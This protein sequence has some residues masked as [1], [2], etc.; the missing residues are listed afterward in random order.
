MKLKGICR[1]SQKSVPVFLFQFRGY[2]LAQRKRALENLI[3]K[4]SE[5][6]EQARII[7]AQVAAPHADD[8][9]RQSRF[10]RETLDAAR[11]ARL[12]S[13][14]VPAEL[15]GSGASM[16][17]LAAMCSALAQGCAASGMVLAMHHIQVASIARH[18]LSAPA[19]CDYL[20][21]LAMQQRLIASVTSEMGTGGDM[22]SSICAVQRDGGR[23]SVEKNATTVS[24]GEHADDLLLTCRRDA[25]SPASD[26][27][28][29]LL[30]KGNFALERTGNW[31]TLGMRGTCSP[32]FKVTASGAETDIIPGSFADSSAQTMV[33]VSHILWAG[34]WLGI[35]SDAV[36]RA[37]AFVRAEARKSPGTLPP[38]ATRLAEV[39][40]D[41]Q[42]LRQNVS[43]AAGD[44]DA[45]PAGEAGREELSSLRWALKMNNLKIA[46]SEAAPKIVHQALQIIGIGGYRNDSKFAVGRHYRDVLSASL[47]IGNDRILSKSASMLLVFKD[48]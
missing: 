2:N 37:S 30:R 11:E 24:Y 9:D 21:E 15:G 45:L 3:P 32:P 6:V 4:T 12:L 40:V 41:L 29:V 38:T 48:D 28:L 23:Y 44:F 1:C 5:L 7:A 18:G 10:P 17:D 20:R 42:S 14:A 8:V 43:A 25:E 47:M 22:R 31:D 33:P 19:L 39:A 35:A 13:A 34:V 36:A 27:V 26:Q 16:R 46:A